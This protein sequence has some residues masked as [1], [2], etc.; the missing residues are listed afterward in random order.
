MK[1]FRAKPDSAQPQWY[2]I[3]A[4]GQVLGNLASRIALVLR[5]KD[6][7]TFTPNVDTGDYVI[8]INAQDIDLAASK[9]AGKAFYNYSGYP[10]GLRKRILGEVME[11]N[12]VEVVERAVKG[13][14]PKTKLAQTQFSKLKVYADAN[15]PQKAQKP[16]ELKFNHISQEIK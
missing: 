14:L 3:D 11:S 5:G 12:P 4:Q 7:P 15:Y 13:M 6:K 8:V 1:T 2:L 9:K 10:S 16:Q